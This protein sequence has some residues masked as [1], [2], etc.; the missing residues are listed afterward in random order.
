MLKKFL[1]LKLPEKLWIIFHIFIAK[2]AWKITEEVQQI[3]VQMENDSDLD[4]DGN[5][6]QV[7]AFR[8]SLWMASLSQQ[9]QPR[10]AYLLGVAHEKGN[11]EDYKKYRNEDGTIP[12]AI[13]C[14]MDLRNNKIGIAIGSK[15]K[16]VSQTQLIQIIKQAILDGKLWKIKKNREG[17]YIDWNGK[18]LTKEDYQGKWENEKCLVPTD[19]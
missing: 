4:G 17:D 9:I 19:F 6:G 7:D 12:D 8:H 14:E 15:H 2:R 5:G 16:N 1:K 13:A 3:A 11:K 10:K 18:V